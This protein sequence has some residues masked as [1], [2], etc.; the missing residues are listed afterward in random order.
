MRI[1][2]PKI[3]IGLRT[4][5]TVAAVIISMMIVDAYGATASKLIF[6]MLGAMSAV[7]P[8]FKDSIKSCLTQI[9]GVFFGAAV[10]VLLLA[11][12]VSPL[13]AAW[14]GIILN[15]TLYNM[16]HIR[17]APSLPCLILVTICLT[18]DIQPISYGLGRIWDT[19]IGLGVGM[20]INTLI[21]PYDNSKQIRATVKSLDQ[22]LILFLEDMFDGDD[23]LP[24]P[25][26][27]T[28]KIDIMA[29][30]L[31]IFEKQ[32]LPLRMK[33][34]RRDLASFRA[35]QGKARELVAQMEVLCHM[36]KPGRLNE[37]N[38]RRLLACGAK[39][40]DQRPLDSVLERDVVTNYHVSQILTLRRELLDSL[41]E[42]EVRDSMPD[43]SH[44]T[45]E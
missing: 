20:L 2:P 13:V 36:G 44:I 11:F 41:G 16:L 43:H 7:E 34:Q 40:R 22:E 25:E 1:K 10:A 28:R 12:P 26:K 45:E 35:C 27:M 29:S 31:K 17:F 33:Q 6:A 3:H 4:V 38:R 42:A 23:V 30:Q 15:I 32:R 24:D 9:A 21:F 14:I 5:K 39:I 37:E 8:S 18:P 19:A